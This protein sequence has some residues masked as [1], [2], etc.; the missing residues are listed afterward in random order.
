MLEGFHKYQEEMKRLSKS[1]QLAQ[2]VLI[3][4]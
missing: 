1:P 4:L 3:E 2:F